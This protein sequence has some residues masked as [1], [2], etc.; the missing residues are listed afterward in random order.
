M[1][2]QS[3]VTREM[4]DW[5]KALAGS[6]LVVVGANGTAQIAPQVSDLVTRLHDTLGGSTEARRELDAKLVAALGSLTAI[7]AA[8]PEEFTP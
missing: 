2:E 3:Y 6:G 1:S 8:L 7:M 4:A 5:I